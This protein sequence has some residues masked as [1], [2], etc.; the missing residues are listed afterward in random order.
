MPAEDP[1]SS[2]F[3]GTTVTARHA[4]VAVLRE[5]SRVQRVTLF[6]GGFVWLVTGY[7][8]VKELLAHP[9]MAKHNQ[10][11]PHRDVTSDDLH[12]AV[13]TSVLTS[14]PPDHTRLRE[15]VTSAFTARRVKEFRPRVQE[16]TDGPL[17]ALGR[18]GAEGSPVH[19]VAA[20]GYPLPVTVIA[21]LLGVPVHDREAFPGWSSVIDN[22]SAYPGGTYLRAAEE[23]VAHVRE[24]ISDKR[25]APADGL[26]SALI[27][28]HDG[29]DRLTA[30]E[31]SSTVFLLLAA[32]HETTVDLITGAV[33]SPLSHPVQLRLVREEP[34]RL[35]AV[36]EE[37]LRY[38]GPKQ[39]PIPSVA[40]EPITVGGVTIP[41]GDVV[42]PSLLAANR[43]PERLAEPD[44]FDITGAATSH[45][46]FGHGLHHC[47]GAPPA[48]LE[49]GIAVGS[50]L[51][52]FP[53][54]RLA[55]PETEPGR[56]PSLLM[57]GL[58]ALP[59]TVA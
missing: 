4:A 24:M 3:T 29:D 52:R 17:D 41:R 19:L 10:V 16:T 33:H 7:A 40:T 50:L 32:G 54:L 2:P 31:L 1:T 43:D 58:A 18:A 55:D 8:E 56:P 57:N 15:L 48:R 42:L 51:H 49:G 30:D 21:E 28:V 53:R 27:H 13:Y 25:R 59:V 34:D 39:V 38:D 11:V 47:L 12:A 46:A 9:A 5:S 45:P 37:Q 20:L 22:A 26:L 36:V 6:T 44:R 35:A 23:M 14:T